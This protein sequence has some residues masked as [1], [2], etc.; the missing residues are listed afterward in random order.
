M[1]TP[2]K[3]IIES[4]K[5]IHKV[6]T[7]PDWSYLE[8]QYEELPHGKIRIISS[9]QVEQKFADEHPKLAKKYLKQNEARLEQVNRGEVWQLGVIAEA[10]VRTTE[11]NIS[12]LETLTSGGL[13]GMESDGGK[14]YFAETE[15]D[16]LADLKDHL[17]AFN[18]DTSNFEEL[19]KN[20]QVEDA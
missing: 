4:I 5:I 17:E 20:A 15:Q 11:G 10:T 19:A 9:C 8:S 1:A 16:Q 14:E 3:P 7:T 18:V 12:R 6:D 2:N 13:W